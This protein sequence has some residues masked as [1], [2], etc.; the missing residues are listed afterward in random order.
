MGIVCTVALM[1][2]PMT[3]NEEDDSKGAL[4]A[5]ERMQQ[6]IAGNGLYGVSKDPSF[7]SFVANEE[8]LKK[9]DMEGVELVITYIVHNTTLVSKR[10]K[11]KS[12]IPLSK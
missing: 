5:L 1:G 2:D 7:P 9:I 6:V 4:A 8:D 10:D 11:L 3:E 12:I